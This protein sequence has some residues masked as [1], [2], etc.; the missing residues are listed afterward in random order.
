MTIQRLS[1]YG[2]HQGLLGNINKTQAN[3]YDLQN[4]LS[5]G[6]KTNTFDGMNGQV[7]HFVALEDKIKRADAY[8]ENNSVVL[9]RMNTTQKTM[10]SI[11][12]VTDDIG[13]LLT[14]RR[15]SASG[16]TLGFQE[17]LSN[18]RD[19]LTNLLNT[20]FD[21]RSLFSGTKTDG[22]AVKTPLPT[23][24]AEG[25]P[26]TGYYNG[27]QQ[28]QVTKIEDG[29]AMSYNIRA[30]DPA[31][32]KLYA[33]IDLALKGDAQKDDTKISQSLDM[34]QEGQKGVNTAQTN[35]NSK[36]VALTNVNERHD[37]LKLYWQGVRD[38][39]I[40]TDIVSVST[41]VAENQSILQATFQAFA[42]ISQLKLSDY[43]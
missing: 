37:S 40:K 17:N 9:S 2:Q 21:G 29:H 19:N 15:S 26:D 8:L 14:L 22:D 31:F 24:V 4:Q 27:N 23:Q 34:V 36:I 35:L 43:L 10:E 38:D 13:N 33:A 20:R 16:S 32:Q 30:D 5:S 28:D 6:V 3:L 25:V 7:E 11:T 42:K 1:T 39:V 12:S 18:L 41:A